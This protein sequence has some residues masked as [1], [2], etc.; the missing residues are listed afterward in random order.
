[1]SPNPCTVDVAFIERVS[2][3]MI[4]Y[5]KVCYRFILFKLFIM[6]VLCKDNCLVSFGLHHFLTEISGSL[7]VTC[8][9]VFTVV[10]NS[11][12]YM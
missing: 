5:K 11:G 7:A 1:M 3:I 2:I 6:S 9:A 4:I 12:R 10:A 8:S